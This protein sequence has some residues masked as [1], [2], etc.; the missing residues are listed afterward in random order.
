MSRKR[1]QVERRWDGRD[2]TH[3]GFVLLYVAPTRARVRHKR[4]YD[5]WT[6]IAVWFCAQ[7]REV[8]VRSP[9]VHVRV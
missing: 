5:P 6:A 3:T 7:V 1:W 2:D 4:L 8:C 9:R